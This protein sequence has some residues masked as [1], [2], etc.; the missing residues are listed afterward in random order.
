MCCCLRR[1]P[2]PSL[3]NLTL[4]PPSDNSGTTTSNPSKLLKKLRKQRF[5]SAKGIALK[6]SGGKK[7]RPLA[8]ANQFHK[9]KKKRG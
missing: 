5:A 3:T 2:V 6:A 7:S 8:G 4:C 9:K 1:L